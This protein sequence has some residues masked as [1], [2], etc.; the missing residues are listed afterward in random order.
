M[1]PFS[2]DKVAE[3]RRQSQMTPEEKALDLIATPAGRRLLSKVDPTFFDTHYCGM[4]A[5]PHRSSWLDRIEHEFKEARRTGEKRKAL[6]LAPRDHGKTELGISFAT[7]AICLDRDIRILWVAE[8][9]APAEKRLARV[10]NLLRSEVVTDDWC[11]SEEEGFGPFDGPDSK[12]KSTQI[13]VERKKKSV[14]PTIEAVGAGGA[15]TGGHFD[16]IIFDDV[17]TPERCNTAALRKQTREWYSGTVLP[18]LTRG[19]MLLVIGTCKHADD[20]YANMQK[21][22]TFEIIK[23]PALFYEE[24]GQRIPHVPTYEPIY[25]KREDGRE[26][27]VDLVVTDPRKDEIKALWPGW[28]DIKYLLSERQSNVSM[29]TVAVWNREY[30]HV[31]V[32][33]ETAAFPRE[34]LLRALNR[35]KHLSL[36]E[37]PKGVDTLGDYRNLPLELD[38]V[39]GW[40]LSLVTDAAKAEEKDRDFTVGVTWGLDRA[41]NDRYLLGLFRRRGMSPKELRNAVVREYQRFVQMGLPP[42]T[43]AVERNNFGELHYFELADTTN[44]PLKPHLTTGSKKADAFQGVP[45]LRNLFDNNRVVLPSNGATTQD[46][47]QVLVDELHELGKAKHDDTVMS[48]WIAESVLRPMTMGTTVLP[49][50]GNYIKPMKDNKPDE[51]SRPLKKEHFR[52]MQGVKVHDDGTITFSSR[53]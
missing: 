51:D 52:K 7:R 2:P 46:A 15:V 44:L 23:D 18:M 4:V 28:R 26:R 17:E 34:W 3:A 39:Q 20:L 25:E 9:L 11:I 35:G 24:D 8:A 36:Y 42:R 19:G 12:W 1:N 43:V 45:G 31:V 6:F 5:A 33:E 27:L 32:D 13:Y 30:Q 16:L 14:D 48:L 50:M 49:R 40:D 41:T 38:V 22:P 21:D 53:V 29:G 10:A 47:V 37:Y